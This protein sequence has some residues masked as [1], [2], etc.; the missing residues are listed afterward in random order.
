MLVHSGCG[1]RSPQTRWVV[2][3]RNR[4]SHS[5]GGCKAKVKVPADSDR[6]G[7]PPG[8]HLPSDGCNLTG[9]RERTA[10]WGLGC[11]GTDPIHEGPPRDLI[12]PQ[13]PAS[14]PPAPITSP[15]GL[16]SDTRVRV[17]QGHSAHSRGPRARS[18]RLGPQRTDLPLRCRYRKPENEHFFGVADAA[19]A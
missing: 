8:S 7:S 19:S 12:A 6:E 1:D 10:L 9:Q 16:R 17:G 5:C 13:G 11:K 18:S 3:R 15:W 2:N 4:T 14:C